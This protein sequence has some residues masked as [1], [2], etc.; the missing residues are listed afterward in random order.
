MIFRRFL[1]LSAILLS[2]NSAVSQEFQLSGRIL[3]ERGDAIPGAIISIDNATKQT[4]SDGLGAYSILLLPGGHTVVIKYVGYKEVN[5]SIT[6]TG[7]LQKDF[8]MSSAEE[9]LNLVVVSAGKF[10]Q[11]LGE[12]TV[13]MEVLSPRLIQDK[14]SVAIDEL[15]QQTPGVSIVDGEPQIRSGSGYSFGAGSRVQVLVDDLPMLSGDAGKPSW[16]F[17]PIE[18]L[19]QVEVIKGAASV[20]YG[21][22][23]LSGV[24]NMRTA[25]PGETPETQ[26][27]VFHGVF[28]NPQTDSSKYWAGN[29]MRTGA[30][31]LHKR[32]FG[33][34]DFVVGGY[35]LGDDGHKGPIPD[36]ITGKIDNSYNPFTSDRF[37]SDSRGRLNMNLRYRFKKVEGLSIGLNSNWSMSNSVGAFIWENNVTGLYGAYAGSATRTKQLLGTVDPYITYVGRKGSKHSLRNRWQ[38]LD[39]DNDNN[40]GNFSDVLYS[41]Y[42]YQ[43]DW[44]FLGVENLTTTL[45]AVNMTTTSRG[46]L[47]VG[48]NENGRNH[49]LNQAAFLQVDKKWGNRFNTSAGVRYE[50]FVINGEEE[51]KPVFRAGANY[52]IHKA[53]FIRASYGEGYR[54]PSIAEKFIITS[55][56]ALRIY[57]NPELQ[58]ETSRNMEFGVKQGFK[59]GKF[60]GFADLSVFRQEFEN[61]VE[62]TFG[63]WAPPTLD[64]L[65]GF[66]FKS[67]NTGNSRVDGME[68]SI[69]GEG[70]VGAVLLQFLGGYTLT[71]P[72]SLTPEKVYAESFN[73]LADGPS[74]LNTSSDTSGNVLKYRM[75][76]LIRADLQATWRNWTAGV[77][78]R[79]NS[80]MI[81]IDN[82]FGQLES[83]FPALF[84][85]GI[86]DW[87]AQNNTGD[88][89]FD[90]RVGYTFAKH[91]RVSIIMNNVLNRE[92]A[93]RP[94]D[95]EEPRLTTFQYTYTL[96]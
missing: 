59:L 5:E 36:S 77:S 56:G 13:S 23:A 82:A 12:V 67:V 50:R 89:V 46:E 15:L 33:S 32:R 11:D 76:E 17:L 4:M 78:Y 66:G 94:L 69:M 96:K 10:E 62:F 3:D 1:F 42:Q 27:S 81:N 71:N 41:E 20:L 70:K 21:S 92:Y 45:G 58:S 31:F 29:L 83:S 9:E 35:F 75:R 61:F 57:A 73:P 19:S 74:Y 55:L 53:T 52:R 34:L 30:N 65:L 48:G 79:Y 72:V 86:N 43:Q 44:T 37:A 47:F 93:I 18:N 90:A 88:Y 6:L 2:F 49:A 25:F 87:R 54:F 84:N 14:N 7:N 24:V 39:N 51:A 26:V 68:V 64:N 22:S 85:P 91:H 38:S 80:N 95:I 8:V 40:Q 28:S 16:D 60:K 63:Q